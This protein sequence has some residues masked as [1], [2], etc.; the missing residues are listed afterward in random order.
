VQLKTRIFLSVVLVTFLPITL[1]MLGATNY[2]ESRYKE[3]VESQ[4]FKSLR[5]ISAEIDRRLVYERETLT[6]L[7]A[8]PAITSYLPV[9]DE[10]ARGEFNAAHE[11][12]AESL[13]AFLEAFQDIVPSLNTFR[14]LDSN[15]NTVIKIRWGKRVQP[16]FES[17]EPYAYAEEEIFNSDY[18]NTL[19]DLIPDEVNVTLLTQ[20]RIEQGNRENLPMLDY[21]IPLTYNG[22][23]AGYLAANTL[24]QYLDRILDFAARDHDGELLIAEINPDKLQRHGVFLYDDRSSLRF[25]D[26]KDSQLRLQ[27][28]LQGRVLERVFDNQEGAVVS[29]DGSEALYFVE[30]Q[31]YPQIL[32]SW[33]IATRIQTANISEPFNRIRYAFAGVAILVLLISIW[34]VRF[35]ASRIAKPVS[36]LAEGMHDYAAGNHTVRMRHTDTQEIDTLSRSFNDMADKLEVADREKDKAQYMMLQ[37]AKLA[38]I[39]QMAAGIGHEIN[40]PLNN[41][42]SISKLMQ[43]DIQTADERS[44]KDLVSLR[45]EALRASGIVQGILNFARQVKPE[46]TRFEINSWLRETIALV[47]QEANKRHILIQLENSDE[48]YVE[49][50]RGQLQQALIN[51][52]L[53]AIQ[54]SAAK[55]TVSVRCIDSEEWLQIQVEDQGIGLDTEEYEKVFDPFYTTKEVG[56][57]S[58]LGLSISLGIVERHQ[59]ELLLETN[60]SG[61]IT[62]TIVLPNTL[63]EQEVS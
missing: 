58:G 14:I 2:I 29:E 1:L 7:I 60:K 59:G 54:A 51:L 40:N 24:G 4:I 9:L 21:I 56:E 43:R 37:H 45:E 46:Y 33:I 36:Q 28:I 27:N 3:D 47:K 8:S 12:K 15:A 19:R 50:D 32:A 30:Y 52:L 6:S 63:H 13:S 26:I 62:A 11:T 38:S 42:L 23:V 61:G 57:G 16:L 22:E 18:L 55:D 48:M 39:G 25:S 34:S 5:D 49:G 17:I 35:T 41:I 20:T 10:L 53:N 44:Q 31:P